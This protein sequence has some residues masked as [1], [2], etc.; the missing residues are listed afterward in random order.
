MPSSTTTK[1]SLGREII[2]EEK[3]HSYYIDDPN[4]RIDFTSVTTFINKFFPKFDAEKI[5][6]FVAKKRGISAAEVLSEWNQKG[7]QACTFGTRVHECCEDIIN[8]RELRNSPENEQEKIAFLN[9]VIAAKTIQKKFNII[10][11]EKT[12]FDE[13]LKLSG[14]IDLLATP[15]QKDNV[16]YII[17]WKTNKEIRSESKYKKFAFEPIS[18]L[19][20]CEMSHYGLQLTTYGHI[21][22]SGFYI[23]EDAIVRYLIV[24][25]TVNGNDYIPVS[26]YEKYVDAILGT[27]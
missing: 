4:G 17:D 3:S 2:F 27:L 11:A 24:H 20:D 1:N 8:G 13:K 22:K 7:L 15:K 12:I 6:P 26:G 9:A 23:P 21:L 14:T 5:A 16:F 19:P 10:S 25:I 18:D